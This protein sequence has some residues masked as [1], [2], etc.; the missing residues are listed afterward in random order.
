[1]YQMF[2]ETQQ[3]SLELLVDECHQWHEKLVS[4]REELHQLKNELYYFAP[5]KLEHDVALGIEHF[6]NQL[7]IQLI[8]IHNLKHEIKRHLAEAERYPTFGHRVAHR[9]IRDKVDMLLGNLNQ[10]DNEFRTFIKQ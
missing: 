1:M 4:W 10:L 2:T 6:H 7:H 8:N 5:G 9:Y 3:H